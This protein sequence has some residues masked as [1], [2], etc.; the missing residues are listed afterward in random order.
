MFIVRFFAWLFLLA[1]FL[2]FFG[3]YAIRWYEEERQAGGGMTLGEYPFYEKIKIVPPLFAEMLAFL[4]MYLLFL[5]DLLAAPGRRI[6]ALLS[7]GAEKESG[8]AQEAGNAPGDGRRPVVLLHGFGMRGLTMYPVARR[9]RRRGRTVFLFTYWPPSKPIEAFADQFH[10]Y[11]EALCVEEG[12]AEFDAVGYSM[13]GIVLLQYL[14]EH[15]EDHRVR[16]VM[17]VGTPHGGT[18]LFRFSMLAPARQLRPGGEFLERL[19]EAGIPPGVEATAI[20]SDFDQFVIPN[21]NA[22]WDQSGVENHIVTGVGH[23]RLLF[24]NKTFRLIEEALT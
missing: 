13:G 5:A 2:I 22:R 10:H 6:F 21:R 16:R 19:K 9:L 24:H 18:E 15:R 12:L 17:T 3:T 23:T 1:F 14:L 11:I 20:G 8:R 4:A 7:P